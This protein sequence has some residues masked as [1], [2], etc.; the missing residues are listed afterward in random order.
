MLQRAAGVEAR[1]MIARSL[2]ALLVTASALAGLA[3]TAWLLMRKAD[4]LAT[5]SFDQAYF[6]QL[7]WQIA[8][9]HGF[10]SD[11]NPG[12]FL[13]LHFSPLLVVPAA[14]QTMWSDARLLSLLQ[15]TALAVAV[16]FAFLFFRAVFGSSRRATWLAAALAVPMP[17][18]PVMQGIVRAEFHTEALALPLLFAAGW[19]GLTRRPAIL[20]LSA[21]LALT[22]KEDQVYAVAAI[23]LA[24]V[25]LAPGRL[26]SRP[27]LHGVGLVALAIGWAVVVFGVVKPWF[28]AGAAYDTDAYYA[29]LGGG[30]GLLRLP[31]EQP[32]AL[33]AIL[34][35]PDGWWTAILL[36]GVLAGLPL[37]RARWLLLLLPPLL[38]N[39]LSKHDPQPALALQ[40]GQMLVIPAVV[41]AAIGGRRSL[42]WVARRDRRRSRPT[43]PSGDGAAAIGRADE[44]AVRAHAR[45]RPTRPR[46]RPMGAAPLLVAVPVLVIGVDRAVLPPFAQLEQAFFQ[47][48]AALEQLRAIARTVPDDADVAVDDGLAAPLASRADLH[49]FPDM[50]PHAY[51]V[52]DR[53]PYLTGKLLW[54]DRPT[55]LAAIEHS[56][57]ARLA[58]DG[59]FIVWGP[60]P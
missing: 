43:A 19:A 50:P 38:A 53:H 2:P 46:R 34:R 12:D 57:R 44:V 8:N 36:V 20:W 22:A 5:P 23:G 15:V 11:F 30:F 4:G 16:P 31:F 37:L 13:G 56:G 27:R 35:R 7:V 29:W 17:L 52:V 55:F 1:P 10:H 26:G 21:V 60:L 40:Y 3:W 18:W 42:G 33:L 14:L 58:D 6:Q 41:A 28:R 9:G 39:M 48:P 54:R 32:E 47:R 59:R 49:V 45:T 25:A 24:I 51:L